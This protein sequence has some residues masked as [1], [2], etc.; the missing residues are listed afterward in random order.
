MENLH[1]LT[2]MENNYKKKCHDNK[3]MSLSAITILFS[4]R[5]W[6]LRYFFCCGGRLAKSRAVLKSC[7]TDAFF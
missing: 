1:H 3:T 6:S 5:A 2:Q 7:I 4:V